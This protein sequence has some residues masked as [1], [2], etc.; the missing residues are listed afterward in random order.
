MRGNRHGN[1][2]LF[3]DE[4]KELY[5]IKCP[6]LRTNELDKDAIGSKE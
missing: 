3:K 1:A 2:E 6:A 4:Q 5:K